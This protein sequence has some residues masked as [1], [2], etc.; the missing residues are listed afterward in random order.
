MIR[1]LGTTAFG[2]CQA[3]FFMYA[4]EKISNDTRDNMRK[5][6]RSVVP[7]GVYLFPTTPDGHKKRAAFCA[8]MAQRNGL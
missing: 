4:Q 3:I 6:I 7:V 8:L 1:V 2:L 5:V